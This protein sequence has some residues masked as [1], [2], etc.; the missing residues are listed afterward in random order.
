YKYE[1][2]FSKPTPTSL[3]QELSQEVKNFFTKQNE[4]ETN[5]KSQAYYFYSYFRA[6]FKAVTKNDKIIDL[7]SQQQII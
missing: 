7:Y 4:I 1:A 6:Y 3:F 2:I 5:F